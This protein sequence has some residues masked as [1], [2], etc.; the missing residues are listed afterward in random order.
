M[1]LNLFNDRFRFSGTYYTMDNENQI[2][3]VPLPRSSGYSSK[4]INAGLINSQ[5]WEFTIGGTPIQKGNLTWDIDFNF[6]KNST[7]VEELTDDLDRIILWSENA[8]AISF[9]GDKIGDL[10]SF[11]IAQVQD[12]NSEYYKW[13]IIDGTEWVRLNQVQD[14]E[15]V[16][17]FNPDFLLGMQTSLTF[18]KFRVG[19]SFDWRQGG[20]FISYTYRYGESDWKS[21]RQIDQ[22]I[23]G[24]L[25]SQDELVELLKSNPDENIIPQVGKYPRVGGH[26]QETGG[27]EVDGVYDGAFVPGVAQTAG[28]D[29][30]DDFSDDVYEERLGGPGTEIIP[31]TDTYPWSYNKNITFDASFIKLRELSISYKLPKIAGISNANFGVFTRNLMLWNAAKIGIDSERAFQATGGNQGN[32]ASQFR[33]GFER[34]NVMP[35]SASF[36][37]KLDFTF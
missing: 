6:T 2:F 33:Q 10:Y 31:I 36:G 32:T 15:K 35:W 28:E 1:D 22:L 27:F 18:G 25:Y 19:A 11:G 16:G 17:N 12:P 23:P 21:Q 4:L 8:G 26:T 29:T 24:G 9:I 3:S 37:F 34:Q 5:G 7:T 14:W 30:P 20:E 13:P